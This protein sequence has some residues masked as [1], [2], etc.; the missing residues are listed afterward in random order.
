MVEY[1]CGG[2]VAGDKDQ[3]RSFE[4]RGGRRSDPRRSRSLTVYKNDVSSARSFPQNFVSAEYY[5]E[6]IGSRT[7]IKQDGKQ[8]LWDRRTTGKLEIGRKP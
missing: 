2:R 5:Y 4:V 6:D 1:L 8:A 7:K 3:S